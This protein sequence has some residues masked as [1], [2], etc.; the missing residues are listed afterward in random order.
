MKEPK[1]GLCGVEPAA[2]LQWVSCI[3]KDWR[4]SYQKIRVQRIPLLMS[5]LL[6]LSP[7]TLVILHQHPHQVILHGQ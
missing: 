7:T 1:L 5:G 6:A 2:H 3:G 4:V